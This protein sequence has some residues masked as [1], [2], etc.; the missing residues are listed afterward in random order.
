[1]GGFTVA[2]EAIGRQ[3]G[4]DL[5]LEV[6]VSCAGKA[7]SPDEHQREERKEELRH[8]SL[9]LDEAITIV[10]RSQRMVIQ[11]G[12]PAGNTERMGATQN[13]LDSKPRD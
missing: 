3:Y 11:D 10:I 6:E 9:S 8:A 7:I 2:R 12:D 13:F 5:P 4:L 1:M